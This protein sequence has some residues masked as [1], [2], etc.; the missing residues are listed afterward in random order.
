MYGGMHSIVAQDAPDA[1]R[2]H[3]HS[4]TQGVQLLTAMQS[5]RSNAI[6]YGNLR[7]DLLDHLRSAVC[8][9]YRRGSSIGFVK[10]VNDDKFIIAMLHVLHET[11]YFSVTLFECTRPT[12]PVS[13]A[14]SPLDSPSPAP[15]TSKARPGIPVYLASLACDSDGRFLL[16][17]GGRQHDDPVTGNTDTARPVGPSTATPPAGTSKSV[18]DGPESTTGSSPQS[19]SAVAVAA[20]ASASVAHSRGFSNTTASSA[21][22]D[23]IQADTDTASAMSGFSPEACISYA[24]AFAK[25]LFLSLMQ[26]ATTTEK[27]L[28]TVTIDLTAYLDSLV[29]M[30]AP[31][32]IMQGGQ[33]T[34]GKP[35]TH[36]GH[37]ETGD[38]TGEPSGPT[39]T[40]AEAEI[41]DAVYEAIL[42][43]HFEHLSDRSASKFAPEAATGRS[44]RL[45]IEQYRV[46]VETADTP[47][48]VDIECQFRRGDVT[49]SKPAFHSL[50][51]AYPAELDVSDEHSSGAE[52][53]LADGT[54]AS[55]P[56]WKSTKRSVQLCIN[57]WTL[58]APIEHPG[59][60][61]Q[62]G[63]AST[64]PQAF[65]DKMRQSLETLKVNIEHLARERILRSLLQAGKTPP[66]S[67]SLYY[68]DSLIRAR[69]A[70]DGVKMP[71]STAELQ[72]IL[73][74]D[75]VH[76]EIPLSFLDQGVS[77]TQYIR[78]NIEIH[79]IG[80]A[81]YYLLDYWAF[82]LP[83]LYDIHFYFYCAFLTPL[84]REDIVRY[85]A[86]AVRSTVE[87]ANRLKLLH[88]LNETHL[89]SDLLV[90]ASQADMADPEY[91]ISS[92]PGKGTP[93][94]MLMASRTKYP[95]GH[96]ACPLV[97]E[98]AINVIGLF[99]YATK[100]STA[101]TTASGS[102]DPGVDDPASVPLSTVYPPSQQQDRARPTV[103]GVPETVAPG[104]AASAQHTSNHVDQSLPGLEITVEFGLTQGVL[105]TFLS[106]NISSK[107]TRADIDFILPVSKGVD[108]LRTIQFLLP[109]ELE[110]PHLFFL[111]LRQTLL[112]FAM[113]LTGHDVATALLTHYER[114]TGQAVI[115]ACLHVGDLSF[116][117]NSLETAVGHGIAAIGRNTRHIDLDNFVP[118]VRRLDSSSDG[119]GGKGAS[120]S[121]ANEQS[122]GE[123][124]VVLEI[125]SP[126]GALNLDAL[127]DKIST[128]FENTAADYAVESYFRS[129]NWTALPLHE[130]LRDDTAGS[131]SPEPEMF[132]SID[133]LTPVGGTASQS[134]LGAP[135]P[136]TTGSSMVAHFTMLTSMTGGHG[137]DHATYASSLT[138]IHGGNVGLSREP[139][140]LIDV[141]QFETPLVVLPK[142]L[143]TATA[144]G[145]PAVQTFKVA[146]E[147]PLNAVA[148]GMLDVLQ[149]EGLQLY[150]FSR[151]CT[152]GDGT[153]VG[154]LPGTG[155]QLRYITASLPH[156]SLEIFLSRSLSNHAASGSASANASP[157]SRTAAAAAL[158][159]MGIPAT[160]MVPGESVNNLMDSNNASAGLGYAQE[161]VIV[162]ATSFV[163][164]TATV[165]GS[166]AA[167]AASNAT[168]NNGT[169]T[170]ISSHIATHGAK[171]KG[172]LG[173]D[174][175][176][177]TSSV[178]RDR[179]RES[180]HSMHS[181]VIRQPHMR[182]NSAGDDTASE[183]SSTSG[184]PMS[185]LRSSRHNLPDHQLDDLFMFGDPFVPSFPMY[186]KRSSFLVVSLASES[187]S[188]Y[189][190]NWKRS[191]CERV[192]LKT[193]KLLNWCKI[194]YQ[195][196]TRKLKYTGLHLEQDRDRDRMAHVSEFGERAYSTAVALNSTENTA[197]MRP[198]RRFRRL[199]FIYHIGGYDAINLQ[200][201][202]VDFIEVFFR[203]GK[204]VPMYSGNGTASGPGAVYSVGAGAGG[205]SA[206]GFP[207]VMSGSAGT[208]LS[209][210][211]SGGHGQGHHY[212]Q[213][214]AS[215]PMARLRS[216]GSIVSASGSGGGG[217]PD[218]AG[219]NALSLNEMSEV[220]QS[221]RLIHS[222]SA[223]MFFSEYRDDLVEKWEAILRAP[224]LDDP[225][226]LRLASTKL[227]T[228]HASVEGQTLDSIAWYKAMISDFLVDYVG[229]LELLGMERVPWDLVSSLESGQHGGTFAIAP[230]FVIE[231]PSVFLRRFFPAG[232]ILV[233]CGFYTYF[234]TIN[235]LTFAYRTDGRVVQDVADADYEAE[236]AK[237][238]TLPHI[239]S[240]SYDFHLRYVHDKLRASSL[241]MP[242]DIL[243]MLRSF[244]QLNPR[245]ARFARNRIL[246]GRY[247]VGT[248]DGA[249]AASL[250]TYI[251]RNPQTYGFEPVV[252]SGERTACMATRWIPKH[253][254]SATSLSGGSIGGD[255]AAGL[256]P[257]PPKTT[258]VSTGHADH[259]GS[260]HG[261][262]GAGSSTE[263][264]YS[265]TLIL[266]AVPP[267]HPAPSPGSSQ[268]GTDSSVAG[269]YGG[270]FSA[271]QSIASGASPVIPGASAF[272]PAFG[273]LSASW[274]L[275]A[276][277]RGNDGMDGGGHISSEYTSGGESSRQPSPSPQ[278]QQ[279]RA[280]AL[281]ASLGSETNES[282]VSS[283]TDL[284]IE[285]F[286]LIVNTESPFPH[287]D[288]DAARAG[289]EQAIVDEP[290]REYIGGGYYLHD[291]AKN[292]T[293]RISSLVDQ[294]TKYF[295][296]DSLWAQLIAARPPGMAVPDT[297]D[298][299]AT[300]Q[301]YRET[302]TPEW[303][304]LFF[305]KTGH[306]ARNLAL[307]D[308]TLAQLFNDRRLPWTDILAYLSRVY[309]SAVRRLP[310]WSTGGP[311]YVFLINP[312]N[313]DYMVQFAV[314]DDDDSDDDS[315]SDESA[316]DDG[317]V[318]GRV[319][320]DGATRLARLRSSGPHIST[321]SGRRVR[322]E[323]FALSR[324]GIPD[325]V[326]LRHVNDV[327]NSI[328]Y[329]VWTETLA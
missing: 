183:S 111:L 21:G 42:L 137:I 122:M 223:P 313:D 146:T 76:L 35:T 312:A 259:S 170:A 87:R 329:Y 238:K 280:A 184:S 270:I 208:M 63:F 82:L 175:A 150:L 212:M 251:L 189:S 236:C 227:A 321:G 241:P 109:P 309:G 91:S 151:D 157:L 134:S 235:V 285:Y 164:G 102:R 224:R 284:E 67:A 66:E 258:R 198:E 233:Q 326:E 58:K 125:W 281:S 93:D 249:S 5:S 22:H 242:L 20:S 92:S 32:G 8:D 74:S 101:K 292:V 57:C 28:T 301:A 287:L 211:P 319:D 69:H 171:R 139:E 36:D 124:K 113:P 105:G 218:Q 177:T 83:R 201:Q 88:D 103:A 247:R 209:R 320:L 97:F 85:V 158:G 23:R 141:S 185:G 159:L 205:Y 149:E 272:G 229:Y 290:M 204:R 130:S 6:L 41:K 84:E 110:N 98:H 298:A 135:M 168:A 276:D 176:S 278:Q 31:S 230:K 226:V 295:G 39:T 288:V 190:Y 121:N 328:L 126:A 213:G 302:Q 327:V 277:R 325:A 34:L 279:A 62:S 64:S 148:S 221:I 300:D 162:A 262:S 200:K 86:E 72:S 115:D 232:V 273:H 282:S 129:T 18:M 254:G 269:S 239:V 192:F 143:E 315:G 9:R 306:N 49:V 59:V 181:S 180:V 56:T 206:V 207:M 123:F 289:M 267:R 261:T 70:D 53:R 264:P 33:S 167:A 195:F 12:R 155:G 52:A 37:A 191:E 133:Q 94:L 46:L 234:A 4:R 40:P 237:M 104:T 45:A 219:G 245:K 89:A 314:H 260:S 220:L 265:Y 172:S 131:D 255:G 297:F 244:V 178:M 107:L 117:Y 44:Q 120:G 1:P 30:D 153:G 29:V 248:E 19:A 252:F 17:K 43:Q 145:N 216:M 78:S 256:P 305:E 310:A 54:T 60:R 2:F 142:M 147:L 61:A 214:T 187:V 215:A 75:S 228:A 51:L 203:Y 81:C 127:V 166:A 152:P 179:D 77:L 240:F 112:T 38:G 160:P 128:L 323:G 199:D 196:Q 197:L 210:T 95:P 283:S 286:L 106:R 311:S 231:A 99:V 271:S 299:A 174:L 119:R 3:L 80:E 55:T 100:S 186:D 169:P 165:A 253:G 193:L 27:D 324:E 182:Q 250:F 263:R 90:P 304:L 222:A 275:A 116:L 163:R 296:R 293:T 136:P 154:G 48:F 202:I 307:M 96:F 68:A 316:S 291:I 132:D 161:Y 71:D 188:V 73:A 156:E 266:A 15:V 140:T 225:N 24:A 144:A 10:F 114:S 65:S 25:T 274:T 246:H 268:A 194:H 294:A 50:P 318:Y 14:L 173:S 13:R 138:S 16:A 303:T 118:V 257:M 108:P 308:R 322:V 217:L 47:L 26:G 243:P 317:D 7:L 79:Q 11:H